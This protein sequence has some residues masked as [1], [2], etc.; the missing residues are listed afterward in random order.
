MEKKIKTVRVYITESLCFTA[1]VGTTL[2]VNHTSIFKKFF[3]LKK[4][5][6]SQ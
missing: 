1:Q 4:K 6:K 2:Y 3:Y 5:N